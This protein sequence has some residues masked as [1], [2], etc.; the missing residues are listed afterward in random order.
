MT[1][2]GRLSALDS[3]FLPMETAAQSLHV[4][5]VLVLEGPSPDPQQLRDRVVARLSAAPVARSRVMRMPL[6]LGRPIWV[7]AG[8][9]RPEEH[10]HH[11]VLE[12]PGGE[13]ELSAE[14]VRIM[15]ASMDPRRPL[16]ELWQVDGLSAGR[17]A[18]VLKAH[19]T[20]VD[21]RTGAD[22][23]RRLL[24]ESPD[25]SDAGTAGDASEPGDV[26]DAEDALS[27]DA[28]QGAPHRVPSR[29]ALL[30]DLASWLVH[31]PVRGVRLLLQVV[32]RPGET[33]RRAAELRLGLAQVLRPDLPPSVL[34]G[35]LSARRSW[36]WVEADL[37]RAV[38][39]SR[40]AHCTVNDLYLAALAGGYRRFL[41]GRGDALTDVGLRAIVPVSNRSLRRPARLGNLASALFV[42]LPVDVP[43]TDARLRLV[44]ART[45][46]QKAEGVPR[47]TAALL[48]AADHIPAPLFAWGARRYG[49]A[50]QGR[51]N[52]VATNLQGPSTVGYLAGRRVLAMLPYVPT[53][54]E[55]R[56][57]TAMVSYAGCLTIAVTADDDALPDADRLVEAVGGELECLLAPP[58]EAV[59]SRP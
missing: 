8:E 15:A 47:A 24:T 12:A 5:S 10:L 44:A 13:S 25:A 56:S 35:P 9:L 40:A 45:A 54:Q 7:D 14:V 23:V 31:L 20:M 27:R 26:V 29:T 41:L 32:A 4:G 46:A 2:A 39:A 57:C 16:W 11:V 59:A 17:W 50:G 33:R 52:V 42:E 19:H 55:I 53:A 36:G 48:R 51:V 38:Q 49:R 21:G 6:D 37:A 22:L 34:S 18:V 30:A 1:R 3:I 43:E 28:V 58:V